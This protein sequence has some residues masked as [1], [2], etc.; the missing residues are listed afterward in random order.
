MCSKCGHAHDL[1]LSARKWACPKCNTMH[2]RG[3]DASINIKRF[4][5]IQAGV[6]TEGGEFTPVDT[7]TSTPS[8]LEKE[9]LGQVKWLKQESPLPQGREDVTSVSGAR[10]MQRITILP[11][12]RAGPPLRGLPFPLLARDGP[13]AFEPRFHACIRTIST[14]WAA[15]SVG[16]MMKQAP[17]VAKTGRYAGGGI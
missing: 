6:H 12:A 9:G 15:G 16:W 5:L 2:D 4:G 3:L 11:A 1:K 17:Q 10:P 13:M 14:I 8:L 7:G